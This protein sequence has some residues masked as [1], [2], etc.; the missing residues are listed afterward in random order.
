[1]ICICSL[2]AKTNPLEEEEVEAA[3]EEEPLPAK[4]FYLLCNL[5]A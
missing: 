1:M 3:E 5:P 4:V 2:A